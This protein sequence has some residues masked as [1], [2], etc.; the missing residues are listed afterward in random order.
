MKRIC[1]I[2]LVLFFFSLAAAQPGASSPGQNNSSSLE[3][4]LKAITREMHDALLRGD[5]ER[6]FSFFADDF[7][8]TSAR[9]KDH[10]RY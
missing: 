7:I 2:A 6:L 8:G 4:E 3:R 1:A 5:K 9:G 10:S